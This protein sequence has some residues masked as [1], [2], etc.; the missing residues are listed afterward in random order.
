MDGVTVLMMLAM[1]SWCK[2]WLDGVRNVWL[3]LR[4]VGGYRELFG[5]VRSDWI[6]GG[7][8]RMDGV[9]DVWMVV[10]W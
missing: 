4:R 7:M 5:G 8:G 3:G 9:G 2:E 6:V 1:V 10:G